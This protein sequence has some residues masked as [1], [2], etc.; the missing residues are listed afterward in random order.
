MLK[1]PEALDAGGRA[2][3]CNLALALP[4]LAQGVPFLHAGDDLLRSKS[5]DRDSYNSGDWFNA[6][7]WTGTDNGFGRGLPPGSKNEFLWHLCRP[8]L[9]A[10]PSLAPTPE[11][12]RFAADHCA[13]LLRVRYSSPLL[14]LRTAAQVSAQM[15]FRNTGPSQAPGV[16]VFELASD[17]ALPAGAAAPGL[18]HDPA[19]R[20]LLVVVNARPDVAH[21]QAYPPG[22]GTLALHPALAALAGADPSGLGACAAADGA[23]VVRVPGRTVCVFVEHR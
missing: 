1:A 22:C 15:A 18:A 4:L 12:I 19:H 16:I 6:I 7:D 2:R 13:A 5:L 9:A 8:L 11:L 14:R 17:D 23:R 20:R 3:M 21:E 10:S